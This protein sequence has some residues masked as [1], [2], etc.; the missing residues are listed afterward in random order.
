LLNLT[1]KYYLTSKIPSR[2][3]AHCLPKKS[4][5]NTVNRRHALSAL[6]T[7]VVGAISTSTYSYAGIAKAIEHLPD[8]FGR[9][10]F[11]LPGF[12]SDTRS[13][14]DI[15]RHYL[16]LYGVNKHI[17]S[18]QGKLLGRAGGEKD[19]EEKRALYSL[20]NHKIHQDYS[21]GRT[22]IFEGWI[23]SNSEL[24]ICAAVALI[25]ESSS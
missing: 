23:L 18:W 14:V 1:A 21:L 6:A 9:D 16:S 20:I 22:T 10:A 24:H 3:Q 15:G 11:L 8:L 12:I 25:K 7:V 4:V 2:V 19:D 5:S 17:I 13:A